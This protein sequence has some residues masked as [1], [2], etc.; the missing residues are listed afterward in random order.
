MTK[1]RNSS[2][3]WNFMDFKKYGFQYSMLGFYVIFSMPQKKLIQPIRLFLWRPVSYVTI[4]NSAWC[5]K[6]EQYCTKLGG[7]TKI[8]I[9]D[10]FWI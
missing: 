1:C 8:M 2:V 3:W 6:F 5:A 10:V 9:F 4:F 7:D